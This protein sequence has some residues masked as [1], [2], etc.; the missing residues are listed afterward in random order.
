LRKTGPAELTVDP[1]LNNSGAVEVESGPL[2]LWD[3][4]TSTGTFT[5]AAG[6]TMTLLGGTLG[7]TSLLAGAGRL[8]VRG[9]VTVGGT[10][11]VTG[12]TLV[13]SRV[14]FTGPL[15]SLGAV[16]V[17]GWAIF[18]QDVT[19]PTLSLSGAGGLDGPATV[20]VTGAT[21]WLGGTGGNGRLVT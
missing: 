16:T 19:V 7:P 3:V 2:W 1:Q 21:S 10:V 6:A 17:S 12:A 18:T 9:N 4:G 14:T 11:N 8:G 13:G 15:L 20:T 5:V